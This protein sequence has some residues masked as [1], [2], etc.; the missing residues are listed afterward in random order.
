MKVDLLTAIGELKGM[1]DVFVMTHNIDFVFL[2]TLALRTFNRSGQP[3]ITVFADAHCSQDSFAAQQ[4]LLSG[5]GTRYRVVPVAM[6]PGFR[7]HPKAVL[8]AGEKAATLFVGSGNL[9]FAGWRENAEV[10]VRFDVST[11]GMA[12]FA[13]FRAFASKVIEGLAL[14]EGPRRVLAEIFDPDRNRWA[15]AAAAGSSPLVVGR[16]GRGEALL[17]DL[18][19]ACDGLG[20]VDELYI[21]CPYYDQRGA[22]LRSL[23]EAFKPAKATLLYQPLGSTLS[24]DNEPSG[25]ATPWA[26]T[27]S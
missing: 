14:N 10:W 3:R 16:A 15:A 21:C 12:P 27:V 17:Q 19:L 24:A 23:L 13:Q 9:G 7:F 6:Q 26:T 18:V 1:T 8:L 5:L 22:A 2:Q 11:D 20:A 4:R 25:R